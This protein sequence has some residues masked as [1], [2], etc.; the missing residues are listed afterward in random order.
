MKTLLQLPKAV[1]FPLD[2]LSLKAGQYYVTSLV[3]KKES[4]SCNYEFITNTIPK[5]ISNTTLSF[6]D[7]IIEFK[8]AVLEDLTD[9]TVQIGFSDSEK[10]DL[11]TYT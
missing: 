2:R 4:F 6:G 1:K 3:L 8:D 10:Y 11:F 5:H 7:Y 9:K